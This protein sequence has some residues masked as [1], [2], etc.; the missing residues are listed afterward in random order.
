[1]TSNPYESTACERADLGHLCGHLAAKACWLDPLVL[2]LECSPVLRE[3][4]LARIRCVRGKLKHK[5]RRP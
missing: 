2:A 5:G 1:M 4:V 3:L